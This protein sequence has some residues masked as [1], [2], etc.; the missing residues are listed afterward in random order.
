MWIYIHTHWSLYISWD[1]GLGFWQSAAWLACK[2][3]V[4]WVMLVTVCCS[5]MLSSLL[6]DAFQSLFCRWMQLCTLWILML[7][8]SGDFWGQE[9]SGMLY[10]GS[11]SWDQKMSWML[12]SLMS[13]CKCSIPY[14]WRNICYNSSS[15]RKEIVF[16]PWPAQHHHRASWCKCSSLCGWR[17]TQ[18]PVSRW[19]PWAFFG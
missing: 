11:I 16:L 2:R 7:Y 14:F 4:F 12:Y 10:S 19:S 13:L 1:S 9:I 17:I 5:S 6:S 8:S 3:K 15:P 18:R